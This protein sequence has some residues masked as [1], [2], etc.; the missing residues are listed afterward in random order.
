MAARKKTEVQEPEDIF[1]DDG[2]PSPDDPL[3]FDDDGEDDSTDTG[4]DGG[5]DSS[6]DGTPGE[7]DPRLRDTLF[8]ELSKRDETI[9]ALQAQVASGF[10]ELKGLITAGA[11][12][13]GGREGQSDSSEPELTDEQINEY[14]Q[15]GRTGEVMRYY[16]QKEARRIA[17]EEAQ[18][19][20]Q[21]ERQARTSQDATSALYS[22]FPELKNGTHPFTVRTNEI[23]NDLAAPFGGHN[24]IEGTPMQVSLAGQAAERAARLHGDLRDRSQ[25][26]SRV[27][28]NKTETARRTN[29]ALPVS[30]QP[31]GTKDKG[32]GFTRQDADIAAAWG[33]N[34]GDPKV[35]EQIKQGKKHYASLRH[36]LLSEDDA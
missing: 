14:V 36:D 5:D 11:Q 25:K 33:V 19:Q 4:D 9:A 12:Q 32:P 26:E 22:D 13:D 10:G 3:V 24:A 27:E 35:R 8:R 15:Q 7:D 34:L 6:D 28:R 17:R 16:T 2:S 21:S 23:Y 30:R 20:V 18:R 29:G 1:E 31:N